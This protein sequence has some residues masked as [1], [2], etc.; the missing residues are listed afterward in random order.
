MNPLKLLLILACSTL[1]AQHLLHPDS[2]SS[3]KLINPMDFHVSQKGPLLATQ[4]KLE[5]AHYAV[6]A[7]PNKVTKVMLRAPLKEAW[8]LQAK[9][10]LCLDITNKGASKIMV[11]GKAFEN[12]TSNMGGAVIEAGQSA[13]LYIHLP[14]KAKD[15][16]GR[17][18]LYGN[19]M[20]LPNGSSLSSWRELPLNKLRNLDLTIYSDAGHGRLELSRLRGMSDFRKLDAYTFSPKKRPFVDVF[21]Q[22]NLEKWKTKIHSKSDLI[23]AREQEAKTF[24]IL[25]GGAG[26]SQYGGYL[27]GPKQAAKG[28]F[29]TV[30]FKGRWWFVD[31]EGYLFWSFGPT[32]IGF[33]GETAEPRLDKLLAANEDPNELLL[34]RKKGT[35]NPANSNLLKKYGTD[36]KIEYPE[37][38]HKR[39]KS[40]GMNTLGNWTKREFY[41]QQKTAYTVAVHFSRPEIKEGAQLKSLPDAFDP[42]F[43]RGLDS[44]LARYTKEANDP[45]C[46]GF[47]IDNEL[48][49]G[50][51]SLKTALIIINGRADSA[52][53]KTMLAHWKKK[54]VSIKSLNESWG[55]QFESWEKIQGN[56][57]LKNKLCRLDL[58]SFS[59]FYLDKYFST[60]ARLMKKHAPHKLYLGSR[61][62]FKENEFALIASSNHCDVVSVNC[63]DFTPLRIHWPKEVTKPVIIGEYHFGTINEAGVWGGGLCTSVDLKH[64]AAQYKIYTE[65]A[66]KDPRF[67]GAHYFQLRDQSVTG[68]R[69]G[70]NYR[71]GLVDIVDQ[72]YEEMIKA[73]REISASMYQDRLKK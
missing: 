70:E 22:S 20:G 59:E 30:K 46:L 71:I 61:I 19:V 12:W 31:P 32:S 44:A 41:K 8:D 40:W 25:S 26:L 7:S 21:G 58:L 2:D 37:V 42:Q 33:G 72:P 38:I 9:L 69:D 67:V 50:S 28:H 17:E 63:Y 52:S 34:G 60:C 66:Y 6:S 62:H 73:T 16:E 36:W 11:H 55:S 10:W 68:R 1:Q 29:Y 14:R 64:A 5:G 57:P 4:L 3:P 54:Y 43:E 65:H 18:W 45:W 48:D 39:L 15:L 13:T 23:E 47:F 49:F 51:N 35:W 53:R 24:K 56:L 27:A